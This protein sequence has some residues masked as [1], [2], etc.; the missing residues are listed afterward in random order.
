MTAKRLLSLLA[1]I[2]L[3]L[4]IGCS[5]GS[6]SSSSN[7]K[8]G[9][10]T[11]NVV[12]T[13]G[14]DPASRIASFTVTIESIKLVPTSGDPVTVVGTPTTIELTQLAGT[15]F[16]LGTANIPQ[17]TYKSAQVTISHPTMTMID[18]ATGDPVT[19]TLP[20]GPFTVNVVFDPAVTVGATP[21]TIHFDMN[22]LGSVT[23]D[24]SGNVLFTPKVLGSMP[25][26]SAPGAPFAP[27]QHMLG[28][29]K[30]VNGTAF[31]LT[32]LLGQKMITFQ[33]NSSTVFVGVSGLS[34]MQPG[35]LLV[36]DATLQ[37]DGSFL[38]LKV[39]GR[40]MPGSGGFA[41][42]ID[43][44]VYSVKADGSQFQMVMHGGIAPAAMLLTSAPGMLV[45]VNVT[46]ST[47]FKIDDDDIDLTG[48]NPQFDASTLKP[49]QRVEVASTLSLASSGMMLGMPAFVLN[50]QQ[51]EL[52]QQ[53]L[54]GIVSGINN[55]TFTLNLPPDSAFATLTKTTTLTVF[56]QPGTVVKGTLAS[57]SS[58]LVRG[59]VVNDGTYKI[60]ASVVVV[61]PVPA[62]VSP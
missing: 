26:P 20:A 50:A 43:G 39:V 30:E 32:T 44:L 3:V 55:N 8:T 19:K 28:N 15:A 5:G 35:M 31:T 57:G 49:G 51:V 14:D 18:P 16:P 41:L 11:Q 54:F 60:I 10:S 4:L 17:G 23:I 7:S 38:A 46:N 24:S 48:Q 21:V 6:N 25:G 33:T 12:I 34:Q 27:F 52:E 61:E 13:V 40:M 42:G 36:V 9:A 53:G 37:P 22:L 47:V 29:L 2:G 45:T 59:L 62:V 1:A 56:Q 58:V